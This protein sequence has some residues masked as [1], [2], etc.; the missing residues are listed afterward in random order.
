[1]LALV[2]LVGLFGAVSACGEGTSS[3]PGSS[4]RDVISGDAVCQEGAPSPDGTVDPELETIGPTSNAIRRGS[5]HFWIVESGSNTVSRYTPET[6]ELDRGFVDVGN[7]RN[8]YDVAV[9]PDDSRVYVT[10]YLADSITVAH[11]ETG[12]V[13]E[14][15]EH[16]SLDKPEGIAVVDDHLYVT[17][18]HYT[19]GDDPFGT[20]TVVI[21]EREDMEVVAQAETARKNPQFVQPIGTSD[22]RRVAIVS[23]GVID[24][25]EGD[26]AA[27]TSPGGLELWPADGELDEEERETYPMERLESGRHGAPGRP[28]AAPDGRALYFTSATSG[29]LFKFDLRERRWVRGTRNP[30]ELHE[31]SGNALHHGAIDDRGLLYITAFNDDALYLWDTTCDERLAGPISLGT[32]DELLEGPHGIA[33]HERESRTRAFFI[34][35][36]ANVMGRVTLDF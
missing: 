25:V 5:D 7:G 9:A 24:F 27:A 6:G 26:R 3:A 11:A 35:S 30:L 20:G 19:G 1:M 14:E 18:V 31:A 23:S 22:G 34:M 33:L 8:P 13:L 12:E 17:N 36:R 4:D 21:F 2:G 15:I 32:T 29:E 28:L 10:N 16:D